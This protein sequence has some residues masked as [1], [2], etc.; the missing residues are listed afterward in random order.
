MLS[1]WFQFYAMQLSSTFHPVVTAA[2]QNCA[3]LKAIF[4]FSEVIYPQ[5]VFGGLEKP[6]S[7][8][9]RIFAV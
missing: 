6:A 8:R 5:R 4:N 9:I 7:H 3:M 2:L 1:M